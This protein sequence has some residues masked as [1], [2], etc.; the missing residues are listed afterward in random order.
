MITE[1][2]NGIIMITGYLMSCSNNLL[3]IF[4]ELY[5]AINNCLC[6]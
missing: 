4:F 3:I 5:A 2:R 6:L 1:V